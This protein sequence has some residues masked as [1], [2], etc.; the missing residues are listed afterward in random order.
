MEKSIEDN[1][2]AAKKSGDDNKLRMVKS[3]QTKLDERFGVEVSAKGTRFKLN[4][5]TQ[6]YFLTS[7]QGVQID[8]PDRP[9]NFTFPDPEPLRFPGALVHLDDVSFTYKG[10]TKPTL[11]HVE[12]TLG[13]GERAAFIGPNGHGKTTLINLI[14]GNLSASSGVVERHPR[15][16]VHLYAQHTIEMLTSPPSGWTE[17]ADTLGLRGDPTTGLGHFLEFTDQP[18]NG[19]PAKESEARQV[20]GQMGLGGRLSDTQKVWTLSGGQKVSV[21]T[22]L[23]PSRCSSC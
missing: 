20:L 1:L 16:K 9:M 11:Q 12:F 10:S 8:A 17:S 19:P 23:R 7:R 15:A 4:R 18:G 6:G 5:D 3:R 22:T 14:M 13:E 21:S 2:R